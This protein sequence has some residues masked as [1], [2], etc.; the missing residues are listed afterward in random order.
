MMN[1][2]SYSIT[3]DNIRK[4][5]CALVYGDGEW[6]GVVRIADRVADDMK[7]VF[8]RKPELLTAAEAAEKPMLAM[9]V[10]F[11]TVGK[12]AL[13]AAL[14][15]AGLIDLAAIEGKREVY[16]FTLVKNCP[17]SVVTKGAEGHFPQ[18]LVI[19]GSEKRGTVYGLFHLSEML[20]VSPFIDWLDMKPAKLAEFTLEEGFSF[21][22]KEPS[23][24]FRGFFINDEWPAFGNFCNRNY[25]GFNA[26]VY[27]HVFEL[28]LRLKGNYLWPAMWSAVFPEDGPGLENARLADEL[29]VVMGASHHEPCCRQGEEYSHVRGK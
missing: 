8:G 13:I 26:K 14:G 11:G 25:G 3:S 12:S 24:R 22:S 20:G 7:A 28:L 21:V 5:R 18:A 16:S 10:L 6:S 9:P 4:G 15:K 17:R 19:A 27:A 29:G 1:P 23:V 2:K